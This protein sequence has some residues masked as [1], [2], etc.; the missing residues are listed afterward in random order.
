MLYAVLD[1]NGKNRFTEPFVLHVEIGG[2]WWLE[3]L[4]S[5][6]E[7][8]HMCSLEDIVSSDVNN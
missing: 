1:Y 7:F 3:W 5:N 4:V 6:K 2:I 8:P